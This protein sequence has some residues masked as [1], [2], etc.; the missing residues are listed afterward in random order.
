MSTRIK[1]NHA[2]LQLLARSTAE[3]RRML[4]KHATKDELMSL[5]EICL[6]ILRGNL[7]IKGKDYEKLKRQRHL[8]RTL[9]DKQ[10][11]IKEK[12]KIVNQ[13]GG[14]IGT[15]AAIAVPALAQ[16]LLK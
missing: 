11:A 1:A 4:L 7:S 8:I 2:F 9:A 12:K 13:K 5:F 15:L 16:L 14:F 10:V 6:N 3:R